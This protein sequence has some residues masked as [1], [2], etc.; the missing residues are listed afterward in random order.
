MSSK[1]RFFVSAVVAVCVC[2]AF[3]ASAP[4]PSPLVEE[5]LRTGLK[6]L[7]ANQLSDAER[8]FS[9]VRAT[10]PMELR[11]KL[12][13]AEVAYRSGKFDEAERLI[14]E[15]V[16]DNPKQ[17]GV[18]VSLARF[19][20]S[21]HRFK[22]CETELLA[23]QKLDD[24]AYI[25]VDLG[26]LY[27]EA[28]D[29]PIDAI[30]YFY[31]ALGKNPK[32][33]GA[34]FALGQLFFNQKQWDQARI[35]FGK[36]TKLE[37]NNLLPWLGLARAESMMQRTAEAQAAYKQAALLA[38]KVAMLSVELGD[39]LNALGNEKEALKEYQSALKKD[40][41]YL[42]AWV[43]LGMF[44]HVRGR[45]ADADEAY[46]KALTLDR[47][48][49]LVL[50]NRAAL[51]LDGHGKLPEAI[52]WSRQAVA[53]S[54]KSAYYLDTLGALLEKAGKL[55]E[56]LRVLESARQADPQYRGARY[57]LATVLQ[58]LGR[59]AEAEKIARDTLADDRPFPERAA[60]EKLLSGEK[61]P[62]TK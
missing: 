5:D 49:A 12:G 28:L 37:P 18:H 9:T 39:L 34:H 30:D 17:A 61:T 8:I 21:Q 60:F 45:P 22:D 3:A 47:E 32:H 38:P 25:D 51:A 57:H 53:L 1:F 29:K 62:A 54:P 56:A 40:P 58:K 4:A 33:P 43:K 23:A 10:D 27:A 2:E 15:V 36:A 42:D 44:H 31:R 48:S 52:G 11:A 19:Y 13:L 6:A 24:A 35:E 55:D 26:T 20:Y 41:A 7:K 46:A 14:K 16:A 59:S 50:N